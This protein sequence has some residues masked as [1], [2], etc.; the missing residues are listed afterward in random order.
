MCT[1]IETSET[2][3][4]FPFLGESSLLFPPVTS[5]ATRSR[6][7]LGRGALLVVGDVLFAAGS[8]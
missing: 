3:M 7:S 4:T 2:P 8:Q 6:R 5:P 1:Y